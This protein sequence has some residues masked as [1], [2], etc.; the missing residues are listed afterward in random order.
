MGEVTGNSITFL[1]TRVNHLPCDMFH[2]SVCTGISGLACNLA[3]RPRPDDNLA[4]EWLAVTG[5]DSLTDV[6]GIRPLAVLG[7]PN[8][9][10]KVLLQYETLPRLLAVPIF[11][12]LCSTQWTGVINNIRNPDPG[13]STTPRHDGKGRRRVQRKLVGGNG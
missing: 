2:P 1:Y 10:S 13:G 9:P 8:P 3:S 12:H 6:G 11:K 4:Q 5:P 7:V